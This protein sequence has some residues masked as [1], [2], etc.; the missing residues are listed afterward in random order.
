MINTVINNWDIDN[1]IRNKSIWS[2]SKRI[3]NILKEDVNPNELGNF[4]LKEI[5]RKILD[6]Q[7][8]HIWQGTE[9]IIY[10]VII[11]LPWWQKQTILAAKKRFDN[12]VNNENTMHK[13]FYDISENK[14]Y[15]VK[16]PQIFGTKEVNWENYL[17]MEFI[18]GKTLFNL[19]LEK[20]AWEIY[21]E[22]NKKYPELW[23]EMKTINKN[24]DINNINKCH[25]FSFETDAIARNE[26]YKIISFLND[27]Q[28]LFI[29]KRTGHKWIT[30]LDKRAFDNILWKIYHDE[31]IDKT[32]FDLKTW[33]DIQNKLKNFFY[34]S[35]KKW[36]FHRDIWGNPAN[37]M[38]EQDWD[39]I[40][41]VVIDFGKSKKYDWGRK[42]EYNKWEWPYEEAGWHWDLSG[43]IPDTDI[44]SIIQWVTKKP[45]PTD[46]REK[47]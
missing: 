24:I 43:A 35:H 36:L 44:C 2:I 40:T 1:N 37:M 34:E 27:K 17:L 13:S 23:E 46:R 31:D 3:Q 42:D 33:R 15:W 30:Y 9:W 7:I 22:F 18:N 4:V 45:N 21:K 11:T 32:I 39:T 25:A 28:D 19:K 26:L 10:K 41:P 38:F 47:F 20:I 12:A 29:T 14:K 8:E 16:V 6:N 5:E